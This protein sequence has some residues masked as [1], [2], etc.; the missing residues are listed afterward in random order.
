M[1]LKRARGIFLDS[2][3]GVHGMELP[4]PCSTN[5]WGGGGGAVTD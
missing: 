5:L 4:F 2:F 1:P 3:H